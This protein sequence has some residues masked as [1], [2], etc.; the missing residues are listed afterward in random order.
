[1]S[2]ARRAAQQAGT[3]LV[4]ALV[5]LVVMSVAALALT[6]SVGAGLRAAG[7]FAFRQ[8]A[9]LAADAG[10]EAAVRW[11]TLQAGS[12]ALFSDQPELG[13][14]ASVL[15]GLDLSGAGDAAAAAV[16]WHDDGCAARPGAA[17]LRPAPAL[18]IDPAGHRVRYL[19]Q[20]LC[21]SGGSP[22]AATNS[23]LLFR[24]AQGGSA[25]RGQLSYGAAARFQPDDGVYFRITVQVRGPRDTTAFTQT[26]VH[27]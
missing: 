4:I 6:N 19:I 21:R 17:C 22:E 23:C 25:S 10:S 11:L 8:A 26:L 5:M 1:M 20:R 13:Y 12:A 15:P 16:D 14:Y 2:P 27:Q 24:P 18:A 9:V 3:G 7:N